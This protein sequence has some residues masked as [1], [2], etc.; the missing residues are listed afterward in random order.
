MRF[1]LYD[2]PLSM[3]EHSVILTPHREPFYNRDKLVNHPI[4]KGS[5]WDKLRLS[6]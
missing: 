1:L 3:K 6:R 5:P 2:P 4:G